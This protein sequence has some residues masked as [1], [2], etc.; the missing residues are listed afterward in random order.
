M[1]AFAYRGALYCEACATSIRQRLAREGYKVRAEEDSDS[2]P[3]GPFANGGG[4]ADTPQ[5]CDSCGVF[6]ENALTDDG[7]GY[8][9]DSI[10]SP[11]D[12][13]ADSQWKTGRYCDHVAAR[14]ESDGEK[15]LATWARFYG[16]PDA[17]LNDAADS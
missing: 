16:L 12:D 11:Y 3:C 13:A 4:E 6:L 8:A 9:Y 7:T 5:H 15:T 2:Y 1:N 10:V 17:P 14:L